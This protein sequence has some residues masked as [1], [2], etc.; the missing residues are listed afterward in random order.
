MGG[1]ASI[2][3]KK[4]IPSQ[5]AVTRS[6]Q[7]KEVNPNAYS[8]WDFLVAAAEIVDSEDSKKTQRKGWQSLKIQN[9]KKLKNA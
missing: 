9:K 6:M 5:T 2:P 1:V 8:H 4:K 7:Q 3:M